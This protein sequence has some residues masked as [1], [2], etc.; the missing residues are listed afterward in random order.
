MNQVLL[1]LYRDEL[2]CLCI[3]GSN[4]KA[5]T[6]ELCRL[7]RLF[8]KVLA[9]DHDFQS[10]LMTEQC[11]LGNVAVSPPKI[12]SLYKINNYKMKNG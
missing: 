10:H 1:F 9:V 5:Y 11:Q 12:I 6:S 8:I 3:S 2:V 7:A 4:I